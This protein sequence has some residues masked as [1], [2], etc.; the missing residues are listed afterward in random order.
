MGMNL[1]GTAR[2]ISHS[3]ADTELPFLLSDKGYGILVA[4][5]GPTLCCD[6]STYGSY[7]YTEGVSQMDYYFI[8][9]KKTSTILSAYA[10]LCGKI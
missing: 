10:Y 9:G 6:I 1:R 8:V 7:L 2:Y 3:G 5:D 4:S